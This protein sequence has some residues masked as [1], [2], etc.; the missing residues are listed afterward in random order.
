MG[1]QGRV[2]VLTCWTSYREFWFDGNRAEIHDT[3]LGTVAEIA[4]YMRNNPSLKL[5]IDASLDP[6]TADNRDRD[7][8]SRRVKAIRDAL[9]N[10]GVSADR[11]EVGAFGD[12]K[13]RRDGRVEMLLVTAN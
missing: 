9:V 4:N 1:A 13:L 3:D 10:A 6:R 12:A 2:G 8:A 5:G 7:L 11:I